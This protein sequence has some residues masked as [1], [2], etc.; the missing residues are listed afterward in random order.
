M[1]VDPPFPHAGPARL[2]VKSKK[3]PT[4]VPLKSI[5]KPSGACGG[6]VVAWWWLARVSL[7][8]L[9][10]Q[11][12]TPPLSRAR[13]G[14][15]RKLSPMTPCSCVPHRARRFKAATSSLLCRH[16]G[17]VTAAKPPKEKR[18]SFGANKFARNPAALFLPAPSVLNRPCFGFEL[19]ARADSP[20][21]RGSLPAFAGEATC[22]RSCGGAGRG[23]AEA[24]TLKVPRRTDQ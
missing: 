12:N 7:R 6:F 4:E 17:R 8:G 22:G 21:F 16:T 13:W 19:R 5:R 2:A 14:L 23:D 10:S 11:G 18:G 1:K 9:K 3:S 20:R 15:P 24:G